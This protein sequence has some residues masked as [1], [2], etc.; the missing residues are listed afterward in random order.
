VVKE[1]EAD[2]EGEDAFAKD[3]LEREEETRAEEERE[4]A[5]VKQPRC[6]KCAYGLSTTFVGRMRER[7]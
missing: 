5:M 3:I 7:D 6:C 1:R 2:W 4:E